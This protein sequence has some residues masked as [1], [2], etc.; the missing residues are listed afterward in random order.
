MSNEI[1]AMISLFAFRLGVPLLATLALGRLL[2]QWDSR[3]T[4][5]PP[6]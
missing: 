5:F 4:P 2:S 6:L 1:L 3:R